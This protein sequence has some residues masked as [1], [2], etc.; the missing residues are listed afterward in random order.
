[1]V[2]VCNSGHPDSARRE[3][4]G[5]LKRPLRADVHGWLL[6]RRAESGTGVSRNENDPSRNGCRSDGR[7]V[8]R[9]GARRTVGPAASI[10][11]VRKGYR[12]GR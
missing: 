3:V 8:P 10:N 11:A 1:M 5:H 7:L 4:K 2:F 6:D 12:R 9:L